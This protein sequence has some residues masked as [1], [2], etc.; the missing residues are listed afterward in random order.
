MR[1][2]YFLA[3]CLLLSGC[4]KNLGE[5]VTLKDIAIE[6]ETSRRILIGASARLYAY[7]LPYDCTDYEFKW[8][9]SDTGIATVD[10]FGRVTTKN[11]G[12]ATISVSQGSIRKEFSVEVY[13]L[14]IFEQ[15]TGYWLF[16][17][18]GSLGKATVGA[19]LELSGSGFA[20]IEEGGKKAVRIEKGSYLKC[21]HGSGSLLTYTV[22][23]D[24]KMPVAM[25]ACFIQTSLANNNDVD[26]FLRPNLYEIGVVGAYT[27][28]RQ[29][30][31]GQIESNKWY[32]MFI[33]INLGGT[34]TYYIN[35]EKIGEAQLAE[36]NRMKL[37][38]KQVLLFA[39]E[40]GED[41]LIDVAAVA[42]WG[43][44]L[45]KAQIDEVSGLI[46]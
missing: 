43:R 46:P 20:G 45:T 40:D 19:D 41:E 30:S 16:E 33:V 38:G 12:T 44:A 25:R 36:D 39:D 37:E 4:E 2:F 32:R 23:M 3:V 11:L 8:E 34:S 14:P 21:S 35:G 28:L 15:K 29:T 27:D 24:F 18:A 1:S 31:I 42:F 22:M 6:G 9:S 13:E 7:P 5:G 17:N 26:F 10:D